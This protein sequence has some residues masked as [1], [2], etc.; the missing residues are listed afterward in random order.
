MGAAPPRRTP[1]HLVERDELVLYTLCVLCLGAAALGLLASRW[2]QGR[3]LRRLEPGQRIEY[4]MDLNRADPAELELLP[5]IGPVKAA[6]IVQYRK[7]HGSFQRLEDLAK[8][9]GVGRDCVEKLRGLVTLG[10]T[11][12]GGEPSP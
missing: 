6:R 11:T 12:P 7:D 5:G 2:G 10:R 4:S 1:W 9:P 8:I 3:A